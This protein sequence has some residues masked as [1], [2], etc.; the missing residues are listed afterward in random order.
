MTFLEWEADQGDTSRRRPN[1]PLFGMELFG[2]PQSRG[3]LLALDQ[4]AKN[5]VLF[6]AHLASDPDVETTLNL[7]NTGPVTDILLEALDEKGDVI[8]SR[9]LQDFPQG[10]QYRKQAREIFD[11]DSETVVGWLRITSGQRNPLGKHQFWR[12]LG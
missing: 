5:P 8:A 2:S 7:I 10:A 1:E 12:P 3:G 6:A 9:L 4:E 11:F